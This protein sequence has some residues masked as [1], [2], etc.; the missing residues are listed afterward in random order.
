METLSEAFKK[1]RNN[2]G[3]SVLVRYSIENLRSR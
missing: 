2:F 3:S 1:G